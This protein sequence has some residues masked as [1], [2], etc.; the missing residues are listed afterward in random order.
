MDVWLR[1]CQP[2][3]PPVIEAIRNIGVVCVV[4]RLKRSITPHFWVNV[5]DPRFE[6]P[7]IVEFSNLRSTGDTVVYIPYYMPVTHPKFAKDDAYFRDEAF[8]YLKLLN[9][10]LR[11]DDLIACH[12]GRLRHAQPVCPPGFLQDAAAGRN[13]DRRS[14]DRR[15]LLLLSRGSRHFRK[16][17]LRK[18]DGGARTVMSDAEPRARKRVGHRQFIAF[19]VAGGLAAV[20]NIG[21]RI[22]F[23]LVMPYEIAILAAYVCG[24]TMAYVLN[25]KFVFA[26]SGRGVSSEYIRFT[27]VNLVAVAQVWIVSVGLV[28]SHLSRNRLR[29]A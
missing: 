10:Q 14:A 3:T 13:R 24:M 16:C 6:I 12:V 29:L 17:T 27:L 4:F 1:I 9:P 11:D 25:K 22:A 15:H 2:P 26:T 21:S 20:V 23:N 18:V 19:V 28:R 5:T 7:G 8:G